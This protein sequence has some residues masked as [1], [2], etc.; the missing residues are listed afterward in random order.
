MLTR[1]II[2]L[3]A[4]LLMAAGVAARRSGRRI[5]AAI[6]AVV[7]IIAFVPLLLAFATPSPA[8]AATVIIPG[9]GR[10]V[11]TTQVPAQIRTVVAGGMPGWQIALIAAGTAVMAAILAVAAERARAA[12]RHAPAPSL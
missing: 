5:V 2:T 11:P 7:I 10:A 9:P 4:S 12:R 1:R 3:A 6:M 8:K